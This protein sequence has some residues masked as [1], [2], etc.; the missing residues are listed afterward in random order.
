M[1]RD[2]GLIFSSVSAGDLGTAFTSATDFPSTNYIDQG[3]Y[4]SS[5]YNP[6]S[7]AGVG[8]NALWFVARVN[9]ACTSSGNTSTLQAVLQESSDT[10]TGSDGTWTDLVA[11][12]VYMSSGGT[13]TGSM[14]GTLIAS[15]V[16]AKFRMPKC[17]K[18]FLRCCWRAGVG[19]FTGGKVEA[20]LVPEV[21]LQDYSDQV[22][23]TVTAQPTGAFDQTQTA[24]V[25]QVLS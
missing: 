14:A 7:G 6:V 20:F 17:S 2:K 16:I 8:K 12:P 19:A 15:L 18:Q 21:D 23:T 3:V 24:A 10:T 5:N 13:A 4:G 11:G 9:T 1:Q 25:S 22:T